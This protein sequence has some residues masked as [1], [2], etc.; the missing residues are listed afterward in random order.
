MSHVTTASGL[1]YLD[2]PF[3]VNSDRESKIELRWVRSNGVN[4]IYRL[5]ICVVVVVADGRISDE[6]GV[7]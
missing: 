7:Q 1:L 3:P 6:S 5:P 4:G 2:R